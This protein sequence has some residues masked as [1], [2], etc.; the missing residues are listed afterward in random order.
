MASGKSGD[1]DASLMERMASGDRSALQSLFARHYARI[2]R[3]ALRQTGTR[4][5]AEEI[6]NDVFLEAWHQASRFEGRS[7]VSTWLL[8]IGYNKGRMA[9][10]SRKPHV[11]DDEY[12]AGLEDRADTPDVAALKEDKARAIRRLVDRLSVDQ[13]MVIDLVYYHEKGLREVAEILAIPENTVKTRLFHAR[14]RL[15]ELL[16]AAGLDWGWP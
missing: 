8:A 2:Y 3:F 4:E 16:L 6:A 12:V 9:L 11:S 1:L 14:K 5:M 10:R 15:A 13:R 7:A